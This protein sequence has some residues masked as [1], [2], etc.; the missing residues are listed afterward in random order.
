MHSDIVIGDQVHLFKSKPEDIVLVDN[1]LPLPYF[2]DAAMQSR[3]EYC[4]AK[5]NVETLATTA[6]ASL[7]S[8][9]LKGAISSLKEKMPDGV[10]QDTQTMRELMTQKT[11][12]EVYCFIAAQEV[13]ADGCTVASEFL[14]QVQALGFGPI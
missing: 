9:P 5:A 4:A 13:D 1:K 11:S 2:S 6:I 8:E 3:S 7:T 12:T 10:C 14:K